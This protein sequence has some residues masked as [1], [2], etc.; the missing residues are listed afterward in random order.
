MTCGDENMI[1]RFERKILRSIFGGISKNGTWFRGSNTKLYK[2][3]KE[4]D[5]IKFIK[6]QRIKW[7]G[8]IIRMEG[9]RTTKKVFSD[10]PTGTRKR[11]LPNL[12]FLDCL[13]KDL[14]VLKIINWRTLAKGRMSWHRL[15][16]KVVGR[17]ANEKRRRRITTSLCDVKCVSA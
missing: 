14:Q 17:R 2:A 7:A 6:I 15:V 3:Y 16:E 10:R 13:E 12:R 1:A 9:S 11:G 4:P 8:H 5:V